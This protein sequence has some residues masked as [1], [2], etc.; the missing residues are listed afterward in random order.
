[1][2]AMTCTAI[3]IF[4]ASFHFYWGF[5]G[6]LGMGVAVPQRSTGEPLFKPSV[7]ASHL[8]GLALLAAALCVLICSGFIL[9]PVPVPPQPIRAIVT[10]LAV[11]FTARAL[12]WF[13]YAGFF[14]KVRDTRFGRYDTWFYCPLCLFLGL[15][16]F[17]V[18]AES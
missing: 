4:I 11:I 15:G 16:L 18:V 13:R 8:I 14:K 6:K 3:L 1:M 9:V 10:L 7:A 5:G 12:G 2:L 17:Y